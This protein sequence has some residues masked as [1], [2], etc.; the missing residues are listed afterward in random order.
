ME[1]MLAHHVKGWHSKHAKN[2]KEEVSESF[3]ETEWP[4]RDVKNW[5]LGYP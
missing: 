2:V 4:Y 3:R 5:D 1:V